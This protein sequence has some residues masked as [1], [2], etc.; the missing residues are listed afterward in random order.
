M[1]VSTQAIIVHTFGCLDDL[2]WIYKEENK[3]QINKLQVS[4]FHKKLQKYI[5]NEHFVKFLQNEK[6]KNWYENTCKANRDAIA[7]RIPVYIPPAQILPENQNRYDEIEKML[8]TEQ[9]IEKREELHNEQDSLS[10]ICPIYRHSIGENA[11][12]LYLHQQLVDDARTVIDIADL[13]FKSL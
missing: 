12:M 2:A 8:E 5:D 4:L 1:E 3:I 13:F 10:M 11:P 9:E 7:H 6:I